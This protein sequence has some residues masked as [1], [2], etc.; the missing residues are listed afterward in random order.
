M[1]RMLSSL[2]GMGKSIVSGSLSVSISATVATPMRRASLT[3]MCSRL[4]STMIMASGSRFISRMPDRL[5]WILVSS[6]LS[7]ATIFLL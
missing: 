5:R 6:R 4:G 7:I 2:P 1:E 3:A